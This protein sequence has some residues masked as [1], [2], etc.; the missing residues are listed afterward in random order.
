MV[1]FF[2]E[3][4]NWPGRSKNRS[5]QSSTIRSQFSREQEVCAVGPCVTDPAGERSVASIPRPLLITLQTLLAASVPV[6]LCTSRQSSTSGQIIPGKRHGIPNTSKS[7]V[8]FLSSVVPWK[9]K[10][11]REEKKDLSDLPSA[12]MQVRHQRYPQ[13]VPLPAG[14]VAL[15]LR[16]RVVAFH[17]YPGIIPPAA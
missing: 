15:T 16:C 4:A 14:T 13:P 1:S 12:T 8:P 11:G 10:E 6:A 2:P 7:Q 3:S 9:E 5:W 17:N